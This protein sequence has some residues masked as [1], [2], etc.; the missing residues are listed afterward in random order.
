MLSAVAVV[1]PS[2]VPPPGSP[3]ELLERA[4][5]LAGRRLGSLAEEMGVTAPQHL[6]G[7]KGWVG[8]L[9]ERALG[10]T[11]HSRDAPDFE[12]LGIELKTLPVTGHGKPLETTFVCTVPLDTV[13]ETRWEDSRVMRKLA[14]VLWVPVEGERQIPVPQ[15]R[16]GSAILW[17]PD[18]EERD[19]LR[20]DWEELAGIIGRGDI[21]A[22]TGRLGRFL[23]MRPK[24]ANAR[25]RTRTIDAEGELTHTLPRAF[26][27]RTQFTERILQ[28]AFASSPG[29]R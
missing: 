4:R 19:A 22:I 27:L 5:S 13:G 2:P 12:A 9:M 15:R 7:H 25:V 16:I 6:R 20:R 14:Q 29:S 18:D 26:Y 21:E 28:R 24:A 1:S 3:A 23:Q 10:A 11:A 8:H 17:R